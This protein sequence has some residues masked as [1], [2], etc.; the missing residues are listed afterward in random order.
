[1]IACVL[2]LCWRFIFYMLT[3][4]PGGCLWRVEGKAVVKI[5]LGDEGIIPTGLARAGDTLYLADLNSRV[6]AFDLPA[7]D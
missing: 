1:M 5:G 4:A 6:W 7:T 2:I 3:D